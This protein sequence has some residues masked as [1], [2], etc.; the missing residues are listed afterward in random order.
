MKDYM[1]K[2]AL[3]SSIAPRGLVELNQYFRLYDPITF[4]HEQQEDGSIV[5]VSNNF[6]YGSII[7]IGKDERDLDEQIRDAILT[8]FDVPSSYAKEAG[9]KRV[10]ERSKKYALA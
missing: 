5:A 10:G 9:L 1:I 3:G 8:S 7:A 4:T 2:A 6:Q